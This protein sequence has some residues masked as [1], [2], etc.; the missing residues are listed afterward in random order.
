MY[1]DFALP[2]CRYWS[3]RMPVLVGAALLLIAISGCG[4][5]L[6][7]S[8]E[9]PSFGST[10]T[11]TRPVAVGGIVWSAGR[12]EREPEVCAILEAELWERLSKDIGPNRLRALSWVSASLNSADREHI[13]KSLDASGTIDSLG[14]DR[15]GAAFRDSSVLIVYGR[16]LE[17]EIDTTTHYATSEKDKTYDEITRRVRISLRVFDTKRGI[18]IWQA[19]VHNQKTKN[20]SMDN[21]FN[22]AGAMAMLTVSALANVIFN[23]DEKEP[24]PVF[25]T[26]PELTKIVWGLYGE[27]SKKLAG[28]DKP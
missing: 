6:E 9:D 23:P 28:K 10:E 2:M 19:E 25:T 1:S 21:D 7:V 18:D 27:L 24:P 13:L 8:A 14:R 4:P 26:S 17:D 5:K 3:T 22:L 11:Y 12:V 16:V 20:E 15:L